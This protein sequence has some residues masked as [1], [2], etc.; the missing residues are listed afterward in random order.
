MGNKPSSMI[1]APSGKIR[2]VRR[3]VKPVVNT[4]PIKKIQQNEKQQ[5]SQPIHRTQQTE[6]ISPD[7]IQQRNMI[8]ADSRSLIFSDCQQITADNYHD[9]Q[10][11]FEQRMIKEKEE[12]IRKQKNDREKFNRRQSEA[13]RQ[14]DNELKQFKGK[15]DPYSILG[16]DNTIDLNELKKIYKRLAKK[17]HP[18]RGGSSKNF[19]LITKSYLFIEKEIKSKISSKGY[20]DL[21]RGAEQYAENQAPVENVYID[22]KNFN[23][24]KFNQVFEQNRIS[25]E[26]DRGYGDM[27]SGGDREETPM[28]E[29]KRG[30][31]FTDDFNIKV[32]NKVFEDED[33]SDDEQETIVR[34]GRVIV[35]KEPEA[36][37]SGQLKFTE[38]GEGRV[39]DFTGTT[40]NNKLQYTDYMQGY[41]KQNR[42]INPNKVEMRKNYKSVDD[43]KIQRSKIDHTLSEHD[44]ALIEK[45]KMLD[46][47]YERD[48]I[49]RLNK[50]DQIYQEHYNRMNKIF[51]KK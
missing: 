8:D 9:Q 18:D 23:V 41:I 29:D 7:I 25:S 43:L 49:N 27:M 3:V 24:K 37:V 5:F 38:L 34:N 31:L 4:Q 35:Y 32:F 47:Q 48:R 16:V 6:I 30:K 20:F 2:R 45:Q 1:N 21:K 44:K 17:H 22:K 19:E 51:I 40:D 13:R 28:I 14:F 46:E 33:Q 50:H 26:N 15:Y 36:L 42:L 39:E 12:F 10:K 11:K